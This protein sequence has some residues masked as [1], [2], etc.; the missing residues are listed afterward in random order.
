MT[1]SNLKSPIVVPAGAWNTR[2]ACVLSGTVAVALT[3]TSTEMLWLG[4]GQTLSSRKPGLAAAIQD[5]LSNAVPPLL[6]K[7][8]V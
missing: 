8:T 2:P 1:R 3:G 4:D 6:Q 7:C 5:R